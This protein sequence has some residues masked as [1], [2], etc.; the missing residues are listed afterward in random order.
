MA[1]VLYIKFKNPSIKIKVKN[2]IE[3]CPIHKSALETFI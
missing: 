1:P 2:K 3:A